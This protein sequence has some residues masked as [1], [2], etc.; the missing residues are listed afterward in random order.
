MRNKKS[1][2]EDLLQFVFV[3]LVLVAIVLIFSFKDINRKKIT[4]EQIDFQT[5]SQDSSELLVKYLR[6]RFNEIDNKNLADAISIYFLT[7]DEN[8]LKH[9]HA[10]TNDFFSKSTLEADT[11]SW[12]IEIMQSGKNTI[13]I[14]SQKMKLYI[15]K[16]EITS[17]RIPS[18]SGQVIQI[19]L[20]QTKKEQG[21]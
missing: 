13:I 15:S 4:K 18:Y 3:V 14:E 8:M 16:K 20:F 2:T 10:L 5:I 17:A 12:A 21:L 7:N 19:R 1:Q 11:S 6:L 9:I